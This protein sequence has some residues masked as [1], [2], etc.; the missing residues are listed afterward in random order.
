MAP[1]AV[2]SWLLAGRSPLTLCAYS[3]TAA[4]SSSVVHSSIAQICHSY[5]SATWDGDM[6][7]TTGWGWRSQLWAAHHLIHCAFSTPAICM[8]ARKGFLT[9][10]VVWLGVIILHSSGCRW[11]LKRS[12]HLEEGSSEGLLF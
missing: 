3:P 5:E 12:P 7:K 11:G 2:C 4:C 1:T 8:G 10:A 9:G 6:G